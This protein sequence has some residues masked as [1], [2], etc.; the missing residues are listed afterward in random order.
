MGTAE[1][2]RA[3]TGLR[4][5]QGPS[6]PAIER[7]ASAARGNN[8]VQDAVSAPGGAVSNIDQLNKTIRQRF[9]KSFSALSDQEKNDAVR[10]VVWMRSNPD[11]S[12]AMANKAFAKIR[13][14]K[15]IF[16]EA[17]EWTEGMPDR[18]RAPR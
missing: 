15:P 1:N 10:F 9:G 6:S 13:S 5:A 3:V 14:L 11:A 4:Y 17:E 16:R 8:L 18:R 12:E 2:K 7:M